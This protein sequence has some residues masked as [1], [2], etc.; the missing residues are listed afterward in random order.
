MVFLLFLMDYNRTQEIENK[1]IDCQLDIFCGCG[2][3]VGRNDF[4]LQFG[5]HI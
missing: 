3:N 2:E 1:F 4:K 5:E